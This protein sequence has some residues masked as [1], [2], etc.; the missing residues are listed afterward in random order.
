MGLGVV[1]EGL[2]DLATAGDLLE[3][4]RGEGHRGTETGNGHDFV[5][6]ERTDTNNNGHVPMK[7]Q[8]DGGLR[9]GS[10]R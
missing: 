5:S 3:R 1:G 7:P 6:G 8:F 2:D 10:N 4:L 9:E